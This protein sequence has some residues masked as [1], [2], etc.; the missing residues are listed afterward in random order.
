MNVAPPFAA[1]QA[2][3]GVTA[4]VTPAGAAE[5][6]TTVVAVQGRPDNVELLDLDPSLRV[7]VKHTLAVSRADVPTLPL[8]SLIVGDLDGRGS[9][10]W[11]VESVRLVNFDEHRALVSEYP[12]P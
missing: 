3:F 11:R 8:G 5:P 2:L 7:M 6:V 12:A 4:V 10:T 1:V 9:L